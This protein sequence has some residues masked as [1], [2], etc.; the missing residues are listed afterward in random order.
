MIFI[1]HK[2]DKQCKSISINHLIALCEIG[3][4]YKLFC[5]DLEKLIK[6][7]TNKD[8]VT[9][10]CRVMQEKFSIHASKYKSFIEKHKNTI[11]IMNKY[12]CLS[13]L[14]ILSYDQKGNRR[15]NL[16]E[17]YFYEY[18]QRNKENIEIIKEVAL[19]LKKLGFCE[20]KYG[21]NLD[22]TEVEYELDASYERN[23]A[24]LENIEVNS[25]YLLNPIKYKTN[26]SSYC[27]CL[28]SSGYG[29]KKEICKY[30]RKI[31]L[32]SL[33]LDPDS[34]P[35]EIT[36]KSTIGVIKKLVDNKETEYSN[37]RNS[38]D[39]SIATSD[40]RRQIET[41][42]QVVANIDSIKDNKELA[43]ILYQMQTI[44]IQLEKFDEKF[45]KEIIDS[46]T[47]I[48]TQKIEQEKKLYLRR[49]NLNDI[50]I[51]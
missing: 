41:L 7:K 38:V 2:W 8:Y 20:I 31:Y 30:G 13:D 25:T 44:M 6:S 22:F 19:K 4:D 3:E 40:L 29:E 45:K 49:R 39:L 18:I 11:G 33:I 51:D 5:D 10:A 21:E 46:N 50:H 1:T 28:D 48:T 23:F 34:L 17:D 26:G 16:P 35:N 15:K 32:N 43:S 47:N 42:K 24:F 9:D 37:I 36:A 27:M 14:T 12:S